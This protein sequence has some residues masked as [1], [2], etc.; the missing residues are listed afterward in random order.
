VIR[1]ASWE[2]AELVEDC[3]YRDFARRNGAMEQ[4]LADRM[5]VCLLDGNG[6][7]LFVWRG[8]GIY[9]T[10]CFFEQRGQRGSRGLARDAADHAL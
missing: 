8:P 2:D 3:I 6:G 5:N 1:R 7:A 4:F 10:H 9:E